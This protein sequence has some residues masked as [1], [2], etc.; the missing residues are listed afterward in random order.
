MTQPIGIRL[1]KEMMSK[2]D[3]LG[4]QEMADRS[5]IIRKLVMAGYYDFMKKKT[6]EEYAKG[7]LTLSE[8]AEQ[9]GL[10]IWEMER[11][12]IENGFRSSY[13]AE[14]LEKEIKLLK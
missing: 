1:P 9:T 4:K 5:T 10:T 14:D 7:N 6:A 11:Y 12:L 2:I 13:S 8:A 3:K